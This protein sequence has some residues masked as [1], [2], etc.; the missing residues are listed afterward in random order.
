MIP[1]PVFY[2]L[3]CESAKY[4]FNPPEGFSEEPLVVGVGVYL[5]ASA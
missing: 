4:Y 3:A 2:S 5:A 1:T